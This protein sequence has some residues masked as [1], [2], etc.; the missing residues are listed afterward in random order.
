M[1]CLLL[2]GCLGGLTA[3]LLKP[4]VLQERLAM[5]EAPALL[6]C[7]WTLLVAGSAHAGLMLEPAAEIGGG[8]S[9]QSVTKR[10]YKLHV[11][12]IRSLWALES[13]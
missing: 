5:A 1:P 3:Q 12:G 13:P 6:L 4:E 10:I 11:V 7:V 9:V 2:S 8:A